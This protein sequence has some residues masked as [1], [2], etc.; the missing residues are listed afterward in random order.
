MC[1]AR[2]I[3][4][5]LVWA[6]VLTGC[7]GVREGPKPPDLTEQHAEVDQTIE[8]LARV[9]RTMAAELDE[10]R[11]VQ[12]R[13]FDE[14]RGVWAPPFPLDA[15]KHT[16]MSCLNLPMNADEPAPQISEVARRLGINCAVPAAI[17]LDDQLDEAR[18]QRSFGVTKIRQIDE[19][20][21]ARATIQTRLRQ[22]PAIVRRTRNY[23]AARRAEIRQLATEIERNRTEYVR[24]DYDETLRRIDEYRARLDALDAAIRE[25]EQ[26][27]PRWSREVGDVVD[28][29]YKDL[30]RLGR[31]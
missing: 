27:I 29:L 23:L 20:R 14:Q 15:F 7:W 31:A 30:S 21:T 18:G 5:A 17:V 6:A 22:L 12:Q 8:R 25:V 9:E 10:L 26:S 24:K 16:A 1:L 11:G 3:A 4:A 28:A 2:S 13:F 19:V